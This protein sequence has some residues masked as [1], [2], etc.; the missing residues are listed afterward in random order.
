MQKKA[1]R[2][3]VRALL[4][5]AGRLGLIPADQALAA[6]NAYRRLRQLQHALRL[7]G[8]KY[9]RVEAAALAP[10]IAA[11]KKLWASVLGPSGAQR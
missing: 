6:H 2:I 5:L 8:D 3:E 1:R 4:K 10:E 7:Q 11:V 9:A